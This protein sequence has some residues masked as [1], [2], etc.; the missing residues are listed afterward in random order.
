MRLGNNSKNQFRRIPSRAALKR[1]LRY[2]P[3]FHGYA[4]S[5]GG[6]DQLRVVIYR[7]RRQVPCVVCRFPNHKLAYIREQAEIYR[8]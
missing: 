2:C 8:D 6:I 4:Y 5:S 3:V 7:Q 1:Q